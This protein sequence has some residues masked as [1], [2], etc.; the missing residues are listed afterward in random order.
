MDHRPYPKIPKRHDGVRR[1][2]GGPWVATEKIHGANLV[3]ATDGTLARVGKRKVFLADD[4]P[5]FGWQLVR[6]HL[7]QAARA[8][9]AALGAK[10]IVHLYGEIFGGGYPHPDV[11]PMRGIVAVQTGIWYAPDIHFALFDVVRGDEFLAHSEVEALAAEHGLFVVPLLGRGVRAELEALPVRFPSRVASLLGLPSLQ[12]NIAEGF[13]LK[14]DARA[15]VDERYVVKWKIAE[16]DEAQFDESVPFD[17]AATID[18]AEFARLATRMVNHARIA[19]ARS[20]VGTN[21]DAIVDEVVLDVLVD[22]EAA[23]PRAFASLDGR[24][25]D[26]LRTHIESLA[27]CLSVSDS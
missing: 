19:S 7:T 18:A 15:H 22:L 17:A 6:S 16:F 11:V 25:E 23:F 21:V 5:F 1:A 9:H 13:V 10:E 26:A 2:P 20:K 14:P 8:I 27:A 3:V 4:E 24:A 12:D